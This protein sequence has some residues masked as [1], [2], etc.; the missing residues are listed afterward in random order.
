METILQDL[1]RGMGG[2]DE[3]VRVVFRLLAATVAGALVGFERERERK[4]AGLRTHTLVALGSC[5]LILAG[6]GF[7]MSPEGVSRVVQGIVTGIG[8]LGAGNILKLSQEHSVK[9]LTT[10]AGIWA[11]A[12]IGV[13]SGLGMVGL[14]LIGT[15]VVL[16]VL[17]LVKYVERKISRSSVSEESTAIQDQ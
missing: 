16:I 14:A 13:A 5:L 17:A 2:G 15:I 4:A 7:G 11:T 10:A 3:V 1:T 6:T 8:F 12:T 9:G